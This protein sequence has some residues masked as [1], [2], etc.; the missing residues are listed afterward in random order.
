MGASLPKEYVEY[1][2]V[3]VHVVSPGDDALAVTSHLLSQLR[4][5]TTINHLF[6]INI[7]YTY[8]I[9]TCN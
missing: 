6:F 4:T 7:D 5:R 1:M 8:S 9:C 3:H 2:W